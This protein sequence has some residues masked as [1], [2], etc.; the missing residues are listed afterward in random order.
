MRYMMAVYSMQ[1]PHDGKQSNMLPK[2]IFLELESITSE[3]P[4]SARHPL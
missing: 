2:G 1:L 3:R 4:K